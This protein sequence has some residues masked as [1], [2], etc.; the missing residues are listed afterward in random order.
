MCPSA[1]M[2][3]SPTASFP[4][5]WGLLSP[6]LSSWF[7]S[8][9][10]LDD[11]AAVVKDTS[12][13]K[14]L[15][16]QLGVKPESPSL[17]QTVFRLLLCQFSLSLFLSLFSLSLSLFSLSRFLSFLSF[18]LFSLSLSLF[19]LSLFLSFLSFSLFSLSLS[20]FSLSLSFLSVF[21]LSLFLSFLS[22]FSLSLSPPT[23][24]LFLPS[25]PPPPT[26]PLFAGALSLL[27]CQ[28]LTL[29]VHFFWG[30]A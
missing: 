22:L 14:F 19:S 26:P 1:R 23:L 29:W 13:S 16:R 3:T 27:C 9:I 21:S 24:S 25:P 10:S 5:L 11:D 18:S 30:A 7:S 6:V 15:L 2:I 20:L 4:L 28:S 8:P 12:P 17:E